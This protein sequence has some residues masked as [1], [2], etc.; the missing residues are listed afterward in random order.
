MPQ[1]VGL[2]SQIC[3]EMC[4]MSMFECRTRNAPLGKEKRI[5]SFRRNFT[6]LIHLAVEV[7]KLRDVDG[8]DVAVAREVGQLFR[9]A[10]VTDVLGTRVHIVEFHLRNL[11]G[12]E[13]VAGRT[14]LELLLL[15]LLLLEEA[16]SVGPLVGQAL[17]ETHHGGVVRGRHVE[18]GLGQP[19]LRM[20][21]ARV[22]AQLGWTHKRLFAVVAA[23]QLLLPVLVVL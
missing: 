3:T 6:R 2:N 8:R 12:R 1:I 20:E 11:L 5:Y 4:E 22:Q 19:L 21:L 14:P 10:K 18:G 16:R 23:V 9:L 13:A 15:L 7:V 17:A